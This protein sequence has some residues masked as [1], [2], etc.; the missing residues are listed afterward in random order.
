MPH[1]IPTIYWYVLRSIFIT[2]FDINTVCAN[3]KDEIV[4]LNLLNR[5]ELMVKY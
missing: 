3:P 4:V 2:D 5:T 1:C